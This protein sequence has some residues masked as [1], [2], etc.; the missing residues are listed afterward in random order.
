M[1]LRLGT[2]ATAILLLSCPL[3]RAQQ[4]PKPAP[5]EKEI[6]AFEAKDQASPPPEGGIVF[7]GSSSIR[8]WKTG[9][10]FPDLKTIN[11]GFGGS[12]MADSVRYADRIVIPYKPRI[13]VVFA[14]GNDIHG[15][16]TPEQVAEDFKALVDKILHA[17]PKT[18]VFFISLFPNVARITEDARCQRANELIKAFTQTDARL[19]YI[20]TAQRMRAEDGGPRPELLRKDGLHMNDEGYK[21][22]NEIVGAVLRKVPD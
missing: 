4:D 3:V 21:I 2:Y 9:D 10:A 19:G 1:R 12:Q 20:E 8:M 16:K 17:L 18:R 22:W 14:G 15:G 5:F 13:V 6:A 11:R 7:V